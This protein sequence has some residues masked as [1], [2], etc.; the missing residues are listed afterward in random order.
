MNDRGV[1]KYIWVKGRGA[2]SRTIKRVIRYAT[3]GEMWGGGGG[4][5]TRPVPPSSYIP[6]TGVNHGRT[7]QHKS[8]KVF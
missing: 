4:G 6:M 3:A 8:K 5:C 2:H 1:G 7:F